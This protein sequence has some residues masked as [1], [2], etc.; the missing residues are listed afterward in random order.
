MYVSTNSS[1][2]QVSPVNIKTMLKSLWESR[3]SQLLRR[4]P[5]DLDLLDWNT[6]YITASGQPVIALPY[7][8]TLPTGYNVMTALRPP[9]F[10]QLAPRVR[11]LGYVL[12]PANA[13]YDEVFHLKNVIPERV[14][15]NE[16]AGRLAN[17]WALVL[18]EKTGLL[19]QGPVVI[20]VV[21]TEDT[22]GFTGED[23]TTATYFLGVGNAIIDPSTLTP[24]DYAH[25]IQILNGILPTTVPESIYNT[26]QVD[27]R[28]TRQNV[29]DALLRRQL[30][31]AWEMTNKGINVCSCE[32]LCNYLCE[33]H[34]TIRKHR[35]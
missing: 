19:G 25:V 31:M 16:A 35:F 12:Y 22:E 5:W 18:R 1:V 34:N 11:D 24:E 26:I 6:G 4:I 9:R 21:K 32:Y 2:V 10:Q 17:A 23:T 33:L 27:H 14:S 29:D 7:R 30:K 3:N 15:L 13:I 20:Y 8:V 28:Y